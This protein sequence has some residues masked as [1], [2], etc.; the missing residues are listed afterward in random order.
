MRDDDRQ[1]HSARG[2]AVTAERRQQDLA[3]EHAQAEIDAALIGIHRVW[4][5]DPSVCSPQQLADDALLIRA[6]VEK[7]M[8]NQAKRTLLAT[9][10]SVSIS[11]PTTPQPARPPATDEGCAPR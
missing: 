4:S 10:G 3:L 7:I 2:H 11:A 1:T 5:R 9:Y 6:L 8:R